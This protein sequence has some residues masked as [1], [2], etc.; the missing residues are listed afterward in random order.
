MLARHLLALFALFSGIAALE[1]PVH[2]QVSQSAVQNTRAVASTGQVAAS[3]NRV[4]P[5]RAREHEATCR[6]REPRKTW[7]W[8][9]SWLLPPTIY[10]SERALE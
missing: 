7:Y 8:L 1:A 4:C 5:A 2:A 6:K 10:G 3:E 9:P